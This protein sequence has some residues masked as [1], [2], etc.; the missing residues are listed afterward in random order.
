MSEPEH[1]DVEAPEPTPEP[2]EDDEAAEEEERA[3]R[4]EEEPEE[5]AEEP[6]PVESAGPS[7]KEIEALFKRAEGRATTF[8]NGISD[9]FGVLANDFHICPTCED[10]IP[11]FLPPQG[12]SPESIE[13]TRAAIGLPDLSNYQ[14]A[15]NARKCPDCEGLGV[16]LSGSLVN[17]NVAIDCATCGASGYVV[18]QTQTGE[19]VAPPPAN[20]GQPGELPAGV[21][22]DDPAVASLRARG[23]SVFPPPPVLTGPTAQ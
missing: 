1:E 11:G 23:F 9:V 6:E 13:R 20:G 4:D 10:F 12:P 8:R 5:P 17:G 7:E 2:L 21:N 15:K 14:Q 19:I 3:S 22:P 16:V 18:V